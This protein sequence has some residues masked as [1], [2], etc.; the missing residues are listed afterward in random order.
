MTQDVERRTETLRSHDGLRLVYHVIG[1]GPLLV[2]LPGGPGRASAYLEDLGGL[3]ATRTLVQL[4]QRGTG[5]SEMPS[6]PSS[7]RFD[8][9]TADVESLREHLG[10]ETIDLLGHSAGGMV[11]Q[12]YA[13]QHPERIARLVLV[14]TRTRNGPEE[15]ADAAQ[16]RAR[17]T[18]EPWF[19]DAAAAEAAMETAPAVVRNALEREMRPFWYGEWNERTQ[20]HA[21]SA[22][23]QVSPRA[24][25]R[26]GKVPEEEM[27]ALREA[28][29]HLRAPVLVLS[30]QLDGMMGPYCAEQVA[31]QF[32][33]STRVE[34]AGAGH[35]PWV[36]RPLEFRTAVEQFLSSARS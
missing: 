5:L 9:L 26:F 33:T 21:A 19:A 17:R 32:P 27:Q 22:D 34:L 8:R 10:L 14:T 31:A 23:G 24:M 15:L 25:L 36:D 35:F 1:D 11:S 4:D 6:D 13:A 30:G 2:C 20:E 12:A 3:S 29:A 16:V 18:D 28:C 7:Y